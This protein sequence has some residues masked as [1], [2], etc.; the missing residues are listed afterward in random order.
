MIAVSTENFEEILIDY[1]FFRQYGDAGLLR[2]PEKCV[3]LT[4]T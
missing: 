2:T 1:V 4:K 3:V